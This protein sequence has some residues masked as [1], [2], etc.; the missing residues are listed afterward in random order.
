M[1]NRKKIRFDI[2]LANGKKAKCWQ[3]CVQE[4]TNCEFSAG[5]VTNADPEVVYLRFDKDNVKPPTTVFMTKDE[6]L[7][8]VHVLTGALWSLEIFQK[9]EKEKKDAI[10]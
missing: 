1:S 9:V 6:A 5:L 2:R 8:V 4:Y 7:A 3:A 10:I